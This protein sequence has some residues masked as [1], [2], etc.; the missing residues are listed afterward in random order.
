MEALKYFVGYIGVRSQK[1]A[2]SG[3]ATSQTSWTNLSASLKGLCNFA[4]MLL[5]QLVEVEVRELSVEFTPYEPE[6]HTGSTTNDLLRQ[7]ALADFTLLSELLTLRFVLN[8][9]QDLEF[10]LEDECI[11]V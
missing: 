4:L 9:T 2:V 11:R 3:M 7:K 8:S 5:T 10:T 1:E 6:K